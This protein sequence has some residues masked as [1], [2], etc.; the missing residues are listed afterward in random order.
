MI[1]MPIGTKF[2]INET[3]VEV[4]ESR[5][6]GKC[7]YKELTRRSELKCGTKEFS[8]ISKFFCHKDDRS[9]NKTVIYRPI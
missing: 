7:F 5:G 2:K 6:C 1:E 8:N 3:L 9:D 4:V